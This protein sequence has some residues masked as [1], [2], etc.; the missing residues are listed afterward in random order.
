MWGDS[1]EIDWATLLNSKNINTKRGSYDS[2]VKTRKKTAVTSKNVKQITKS[3]LLSHMCPVC[4]RVFKPKIN[5]T[6]SRCFI[7]HVQKCKENDIKS[8]EEK[9][10]MI[11]NDCPFNFSDALF[12]DETAFVQAEFNSSNLVPELDIC[13]KIAINMNSGSFHMLL[14]NINSIYNKYEHIY[15]ILNK[16]NV[17]IIA[18]NEVKLSNDVPDKLYLHPKYKLLRRD[19]NANG[20]G[21]MVY[22]KKNYHL[23]EHAP[24]LDFE[25]VSF[26]LIIDK[27]VN[28]FVVAYKPPDVNHS[29]FLEHLDTQ[30]KRFDLSKNLFI[31]G[32]LNMDWFSDKGNNLKRFCT[33]NDLRNFVK[34][35]TRTAT[36]KNGLTS[37]TCIDVVLHNSSQV[38]KSTVINFAFSDHNLILTECNFKTDKSSMESSK[39]TRNLNDTNVNL[40]SDKISKINFDFICN[41]NDLDDCLF[42]I[43]K[44]VIDIID[45]VAPLK[46]KPNKKKSN[47]L[48]WYNNLCKKLSK[49]CQ[50]NCSILNKFK[51]NKNNMDS[52]GKIIDLERLRLLEEN[53]ISSRQNYQSKLRESKIRYFE[54]KTTEN[55]KSSKKL[56]TFYQ[57]FYKMRSDKSSNKCPDSI[58][59]D[60][61]VLNDR[62]DITNAF[63]KQFSSFKSEDLVSEF[64]CIKYINESFQSAKFKLPINQFSFSH[65]N[66]KEVSN[67]I[68]TS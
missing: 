35:P 25:M 32:D 10:N 23:I 33:E 28:N 34:E 27:I 43:E 41:L 13:D 7:K 24:S 48:P 49:I 53:F 30:I 52:N 1:A 58:N 16:T 22:V 8:N 38:C 59:V 21:I 12:H 37:S 63:N 36:N 6:E 44:S 64:D 20:G 54:D 61:N 66:V 18:L 3:A 50:K 29:D 17:D 55:L 14:L 56:Y 5:N 15:D 31:L 11:K 68:N 19:R 45:D 42:T 39:K 4:S 67:L 60:G 46:N 47:N 57:P 40:I 9:L 26:S 51:N 2:E 62:V 65:T